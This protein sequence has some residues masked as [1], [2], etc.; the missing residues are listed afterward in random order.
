M[1]DGVGRIETLELGHRVPDG[2]IKE[3][4]ALLRAQTGLFF[5]KRLFNRLVPFG[6]AWANGGGQ[7]PLAQENQT[8]QDS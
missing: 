2:G 8:I 6:E 7:G 1:R 4:L 5:R 3:V